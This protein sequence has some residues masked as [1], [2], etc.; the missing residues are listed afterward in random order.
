MPIYACS[1]GKYRIGDGECMYTSRE[2]AVRAY[3]AYLAQHPEAASES[4]AADMDKVS[5]DFDGTISKEQWQQKAMQL[6]DQGK[7]LYIVTR[8]QE[9][10]SE[11]VYAVADKIG[12][13]HSRVYFTNGKL[14]WE[15]IKRLGIG[16]HYDNNEDEI[17]A[18]RENTDATAKLVSEGKSFNLK[19]E[20][21]NDYP[22]AATNNAKRALKWKEENGSDCGTPVGWTR[23]NQLANREKI[24][25]DTIARMASFKRH[26]QNKDVPYSEGCGGLMWDAWGG[27][28]GI[29]WAIRKLDQIDN[30]KSM[31][32]NYK[33]LSL[34]VKD[35]DTKQGIVTG[36]F[37]AFGN[38]DSD[39]DIMMPGAFKR[40]IQDWGPEG[41][42]RIKHLLNHD[43]SKPLG[44]IQVLKEDEYGLYYESKVGT[45]TLGKDYIKMIESG[46]IAEHSIGFKTLRE[47]KS[48]DANQIH[49][50]MLFEGSS[51]TAWGANE[52]TPLLG[53]KNMNNIEQIQDQIKSFEK[54]IR[55]SDVTDETIDLCILKVKQL[56]ELVERMSST[57]AVD[58]TPAQQKEEEV[59]VESF[60]NIINKF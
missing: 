26:Q 11:P 15:T 13:P 58:E 10:D 45:H 51:L 29:N 20:T 3:Q 25:R 33:S 31:I 28:A 55:N 36:Y 40:S 22:E 1:N 16:T 24:S 59:P 43:P 42:G 27:D 30:R 9:S 14:K 41:K 12:I 57:K 46:L 17:K 5:F 23:A 48:G 7:T 47:Q 53:M 52:A 2:N 54:F 18:I 38:V 37:S 4:K 39:G 32:Y 44:K 6:K 21:Y 60:I 19:E 50:V 35:V 34:E 8:R 56:A 49:E